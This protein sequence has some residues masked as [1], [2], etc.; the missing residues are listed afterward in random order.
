MTKP[1]KFLNRIVIHIFKGLIE[2][3]Y[4]SKTTLKTET[5]SAVKDDSP[6]SEFPRGLSSAKECQPSAPRS[7]TGN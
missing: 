3:V 7:V 5:Q 1:I 6:W 4:F 2:A